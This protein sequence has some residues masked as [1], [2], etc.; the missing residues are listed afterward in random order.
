MARP[1]STPR[2][3]A[4]LRRY[5]RVACGLY[6][7]AADE[8][9]LIALQDRFPPSPC[10]RTR[11]HITLRGASRPEGL[12]V[13]LEA[14]AARARDWSAIE[15]QLERPLLGEDPASGMTIVLEVV[16]SAELLAL[17]RGVAGAVAAALPLVGP[18]RAFV[19]HV[20]LYRREVTPLNARA[21]AL[22]RSLSL[23]RT[24]TIDRISIAGERA[25]A[26]YPV[27]HF[28]LRVTSS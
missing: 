5:D 3:D 20:T 11:P 2:P 22:A 18:P 10:R 6:F 7:A 8:R 24:V 28:P 19:P 4:A 21:R 16:P 9:A 13:A 1:S 25:G 26:W 15:V 17:E 27:R 12:A 23:R 14:L